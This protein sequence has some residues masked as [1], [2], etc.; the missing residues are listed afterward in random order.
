LDDAEKLPDLSL[1]SCFRR[2]KLVPAKA[3]IGSPDSI[4]RPGFLLEFI[5]HSD[6]GQERQNRIKIELFS[7]L[8]ITNNQ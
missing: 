3:G 5:P 2:G 6:A 8:L 4:E 1:S 7:T